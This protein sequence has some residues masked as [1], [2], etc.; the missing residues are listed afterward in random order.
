[1]PA[2]TGSIQEVEQLFD[3]R[4][5]LILSGED[6]HRGFHPDAAAIEKAERFIESVNYLR[7]EAISSQGNNI[8]ALAASRTPLSQH[9]WR[10]VLHDNA[11]ATDKRVPTN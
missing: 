4:E 9:E 10:D 1:M 5:H 7:R 8:G 3:F 2:L 11:S 6:L